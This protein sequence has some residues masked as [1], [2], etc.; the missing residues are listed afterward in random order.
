MMFGYILL[1]IR[2]KRLQSRAEGERELV[3]GDP[4]RCWPLAVL[5]CILR[6]FIKNVIFMYQE[7]KNFSFYRVYI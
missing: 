2:M 3:V 1:G 7:V 5:S 6:L 4:R